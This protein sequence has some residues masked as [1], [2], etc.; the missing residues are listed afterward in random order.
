MKEPGWLSD[1]SD[2]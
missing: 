2:R 1:T